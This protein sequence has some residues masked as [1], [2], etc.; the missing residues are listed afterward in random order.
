MNAP[1]TFQP[2]GFG[3]PK[4]PVNV[5]GNMSVNGAVAV[6]PRAPQYNPRG[7]SAQTNKAVQYGPAYVYDYLSWG[8][9]GVGLS[10][11]TFFQRAAGQAGVTPEDTNMQ[12]PGNMG[13]GNTFIVR[14]IWVSLLLGADYV[15]TAADATVAA[16]NAL[17]DF[18]TIMNRGWFQFYVNNTPLLGNGIGPLLMLAAPPQIAVGGG[19]GTGS[20]NA[21]QALAPFAINSG[22]NCVMYPFNLNDQ[23]P[24]SAQVNF[25]GTPPTIPSLNGA[26]KIGI[27][28]EGLYG[29]PAS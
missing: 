26:T 25:Y 23:L 24:F 16:T 28:L 5:R 27:V 6:T 2:Y 17:D 14:N 8:A 13:A 7:F 18:K 4:A 10:S 1:V 11:Y 21:I 3:S 15:T 12:T 29:R 22:Y 19:I 20:A 9:A